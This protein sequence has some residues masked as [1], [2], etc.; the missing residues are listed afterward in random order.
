[1]RIEQ[2]VELSQRQPRLFHC[3]TEAEARRALHQEAR[4]GL[5]AVRK[6]LS[7]RWMYDARGSE[8]FDA[9]TRLP[10]YYLTRCEQKLLEQHA[11]QAVRRSG[12]EAL[13]ELGSGASRK[14]LALLS[15]F[16]EAGQL[17]H[18][19]PFDVCAPALRRA[20]ST[21][22]QRFPALAVDGVVGDFERHL[23]HIPAHG[24][25]M[26]AFLGSTIGNLKPDARAA[27]LGSLSGALR[28][29]E[30]LL[31]GVDLLKDRA[32]L[33]AAYNDA[34][35]VTADFNLNVLNMLNRELHAQ[36]I[37]DHFRHVARFSEEHGW[38][39]MLL[40]ATQRQSVAIAE[41]GVTVRFDEGETLRT[42]ISTKFKPAQ[43]EAELAQAH[44]GI[45]EWWTDE[46][47]YFALLLAEKL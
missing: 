40:Q 46:L 5:T 44:F 9:I 10:E 16:E 21:V 43:V 11:A 4:A 13:V 25:R 6:E 24:R 12:A 14:T 30:T 27:L 7:P 3:W 37:P 47:G 22:S 1:M 32:V 15:A 23:A 28:C 34:Q 19:T 29:G 35:G 31:L 18:F 38:I 20:L 45:R 2:E 36:F 39:E 33:H 26:V 8:L 17:R 41:L 42:E